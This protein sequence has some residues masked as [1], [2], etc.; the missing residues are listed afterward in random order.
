M[1]VD[2]QMNKDMGYIY[3]GTLALKRKEILP[4]VAI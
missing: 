1:S 3:S 4:F 2:R